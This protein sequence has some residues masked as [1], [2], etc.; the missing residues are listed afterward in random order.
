[1]K[2][3]ATAKRGLVFDPLRVR[4]PLRSER[5]HAYA[6]G[7]LRAIPGLGS[8]SRVALAVHLAWQPRPQVAADCLMCPE[9][10]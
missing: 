2:T 5:A 4:V 10:F 8:G 6:L 1:M 9:P 3:L 7:A